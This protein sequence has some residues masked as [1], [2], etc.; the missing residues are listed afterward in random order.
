MFYGPLHLVIARHVAAE[1]GA[2]G[3]GSERIVDLGCGTGAAG[4][5]CAL[6]SDS[7]L[8]LAG[9][10]LNPW[11]VAEAD[12]TWRRLGLAG[13]VRRGR[14]ER[15][16]IGRRSAIVLGWVVNELDEATRREILERVLDATR[17][18]ARILVLEPISRRAV[19][20]WNEWADAFA[21]RGGRDDTWR[22]PADLPDRWRDLD[23]AAG[24]DHRELTAR[25][26]CL[27]AQ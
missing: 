25:S 18:G 3:S 26:L 5:G 19:P 11:A 12:W 10:D 22:I 1:T 17:G 13:S 23:R 6:A 27:E 20:W 15:A 9:V 24:L 7:R 16:E 8:P 4:A 2:A 21:G 14:I